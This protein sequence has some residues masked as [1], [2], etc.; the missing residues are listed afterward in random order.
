MKHSILLTGSTGYLGT[1]LVSKL[2]RQANVERILCP[3]RKESPE[4]FWES[5]ASSSKQYDLKLNVSD[6]KSK[7]EPIKIDL[8]ANRNSLLKSLEPY[9]K[10]VTVVHNLA[11]EAN[12]GVPIDFFKPWMEI[13]EQLTEFCMDSKY[14]KQLLST[15][16]YGHYLL[17]HKHAAEDYY[18]INGYFGYKKWLN[19]YLSKKFSQG[20]KGVLFE[21]AYV[22]GRFDPGQSYMFWR[23]ARIFAALEYACQYK[24]LLTPIDMIMDNY[25]LALNSPD[26][27]PNILS[28]FIPEPFD[29]P[30]L[31]QKLVPN[32]KLIDYEMFRKEVDEKLAKRSKYFGPN[33]VHC[34]EETLKTTKAVFHPLYDIS[35]YNNIDAAA[36]FFSCG[37]LKEALQLGQKDKLGFQNN[38]QKQAN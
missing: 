29:L 11:C 26:A 10:T 19:T 16:S 34:M 33:L 37:S 32:L 5:F 28:P 6:L 14:P 25:M 18:W 21:P 22:V 8:V 23:V 15:G 13:T 12:Y 36:Y 30:K 7:I 38:K 4:L 9:N 27:V 31:I 3:T 20:L 35:K 1:H 17:D 24:M 2:L